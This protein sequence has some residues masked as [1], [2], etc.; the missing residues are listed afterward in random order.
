TQGAIASID[1]S[2]DNMEFSN[3]GVG[4]SVLLSQNG[5]YYVH[6]LDD[7]VNP[8][9]W[10]HVSHTGVSAFELWD[11][12]GNGTHPDFSGTA[13]AI[14]FGYYTGNVAELFHES[15][16]GID[17]WSVTVNSGVEP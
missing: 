4:Y 11:T 7:A 17:N 3:Y 1:F 5:T 13:A 14:R 8:P 9:F 6:G 12:R 15:L 2:F 16:S 10:T